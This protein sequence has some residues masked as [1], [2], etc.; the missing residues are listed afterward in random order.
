ME[1][2]QDEPGR[3]RLPAGRKVALAARLAEMG[4]AS[5]AQLADEFGVSAD[6]IRRDLDRLDADGVVVRTHGGAMSV[7]VASMP[8][9]GLD[10]RLRLHTRAK[11]SIATAAAG[12]IGNGT[13]LLVN[14]GTTTLAFAR[15]LREHRDLT[16]ATNSL[17]LPG[18]IHPA[19]LRSLYLFGGPVWFNSQATVGPLRVAGAGGERSIRADVAVIG[20]GAID[21][22]D[23]YSTS[24]INEAETMGAMMDRAARV[25]VLADHTK[26]DR[27]LFAQVAPLERADVLVTDAEPDAPLREALEAAEV[28]IIVA[29]HRA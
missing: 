15:A 29:S 13:S 16:V 10:V 11:E 17:R 6:T 24:Q 23:G 25:I 27:C 2:G 8:D 3:K 12:L 18:E 1:D 28:E 7:G 9:T 26:F 20:V 19:A 5:V 14:A 4:Q 21:P 22:T